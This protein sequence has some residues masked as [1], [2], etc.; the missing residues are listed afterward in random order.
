MQR[1]DGAGAGLPHRRVRHGHSLEPSMSSRSSR[2]RVLHVA[3]IV[4]GGF[5]LCF[6]GCAASAARPATRAASAQPPTTIPAVTPESL[7]A[8]TS[9]P[10]PAIPSVTPSPTPSP[11]AADTPA[12]AQTLAPEV[13]PTPEPAPSPPPPAPPPAR[14]I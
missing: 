9:T 13:S 8:V 5:A 14:L 10:L 6:G 12:P 1:D 11:T 4:S 7:I 3:A 2:L